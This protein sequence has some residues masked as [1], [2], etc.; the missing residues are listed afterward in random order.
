MILAAIEFAHT[1]I[2][3]IVAAIEEL[4]SKAA[5]RSVPLPPPSSTKLI[6]LS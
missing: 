4:A 5:K 2:K 1:E 3:K 6:M